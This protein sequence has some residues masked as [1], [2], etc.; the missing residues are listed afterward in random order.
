MGAVY[1]FTR[2]S[3]VIAGIGTLCC[4]ALAAWLTFMAVFLVP[5]LGGIAVY[6]RYRIGLLTSLFIGLVGCY[7]GLYVLLEYNYVDSFL[8]ALKQ[9]IVAAIQDLTP[10]SRSVRNP[11]L[12]WVPPACRPGEVRS[13]A[14]RECRRDCTVFHAVPLC[15]VH[16]RDC[17]APDAQR[18]VRSL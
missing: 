15:A 8:I 11:E 16:S 17:G 13:H 9:Q 14:H 3:R 2:E 12:Q 5:V 10:T 18:D 6:R 4:L 1:C 7:I